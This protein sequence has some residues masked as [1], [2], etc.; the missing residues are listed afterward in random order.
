[1]FTDLNLDGNPSLSC[2]CPVEAVEFGDRRAGVLR[3]AAGQGTAATA[4]RGRRSRGG[5]EPRR[6][7]GERACWSDERGPRSTRRELEVFTRTSLAPEVA[8]RCG[9]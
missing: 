1:M 6:T 4:L 8:G 3:S 5:V 9:E 2:E 7:R